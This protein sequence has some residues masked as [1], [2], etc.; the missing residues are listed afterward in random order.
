MFGITKVSTEMSPYSIL[1]LSGDTW[2]FSPIPTQALAV[3]H[4][5]PTWSTWQN[6]KARRVVGKLR[7]KRANPCCTFCALEFH[8][9]AP[10][11]SL[12]KPVGIQ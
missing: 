6:W 7:H 12:E 4:L 5:S 1:L 10:A 11:S 3:S 9:P 8:S 2:F